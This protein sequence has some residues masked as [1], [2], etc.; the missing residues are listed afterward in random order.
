MK[1]AK[2]EA[3]AA[4]LKLRDNVPIEPLMSDMNLQTRNGATA[5]TKAK[6]AYLMQTRGPHFVEELCRIIDGVKLV[7]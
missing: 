7:R 3:K 4:K 2:L 6:D 5:R 1:L